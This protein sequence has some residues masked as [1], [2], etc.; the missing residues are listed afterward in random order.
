MAGGRDFGELRGVS[1]GTPAGKPAAGGLELLLWW[2]NDDAEANVERSAP[3]K[4]ESKI[5]IESAVS[6]VKLLESSL[7]FRS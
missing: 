7:E 6:P 1:Q 5:Q 3:T 4:E 2:K